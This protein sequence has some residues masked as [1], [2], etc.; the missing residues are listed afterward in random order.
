MHQQPQLNISIAAQIRYGLCTLLLL[1]VLMPGVFQPFLTRSWDFIRSLTVFQWSTFETLWTVLCYSLAELLLTLVFLK[2]PEWRLQ[3]GHTTKIIEKGE[4]IPQGSKRTRPRG[5][6]RPSRRLMEGLIYV[7][8]LLTMDLTMIKKFAGVPLSEML[9]TGNHHKTNPLSQINETSNGLLS[10][11]SSFLVPTFHNFTLDSPLQ[12]RRALPLLAPSST[13]L[14]LELITSIILFDLLFFL[15]HLLLHYVPTLHSWHA[16]HH[17]HDAQLNP[18][19]TNQLSVP[20]RLGLVLLANF[21]LNIIGAHVLTRTLFVPIFV[22]LLIEIHCGLDLPWGYEKILPA[23]WGGGAK[24]HMRHHRFGTA[25]FEP[26]F[27]WCDAELERIQR[28]MA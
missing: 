14:S 19:V 12:I 8:P 20:E 28:R 1:S 16:P 23:G 9:E 22:W 4:K 21:S 7:L 26:F 2:R 15:F 6:R 25:D 24:K 10:P 5:M 27:C 17:K 11:R 18:Q 13:R 3:T